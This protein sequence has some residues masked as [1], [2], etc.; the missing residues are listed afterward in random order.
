MSYAREF[1][2]GCAAVQRR[3]ERAIW[4]HAFDVLGDDA[5]ELR[6]WHVEQAAARP[7]AVIGALRLEVLEERVRDGGAP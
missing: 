5:G 6:R 2:S 1:A 7:D 4:G 3:Y